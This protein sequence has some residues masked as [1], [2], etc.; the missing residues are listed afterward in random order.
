MKQRF[1]GA[2]VD[3]GFG[4]AVFVGLGVESSSSSPGPVLVVPPPAAQPARTRTVSSEI[5][6]LVFIGENLRPGTAATER[7]AGCDTKNAWNFRRSPA[8]VPMHP[9]SATRVRAYRANVLKRARL[10]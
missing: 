1:T 2:V 3:V 5:Q 6:R 9:H 4:D 10:F 7:P 8:W